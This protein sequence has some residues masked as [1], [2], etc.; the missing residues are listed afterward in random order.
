MYTV[1]SII[2][3]FS[4]VTCEGIMWKSMRCPKHRMEVL[5][6]SSTIILPVNVMQTSKSK[7]TEY[8]SC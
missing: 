6:N 1:G 8:E 7:A 4:A 5:N 3:D 2:R